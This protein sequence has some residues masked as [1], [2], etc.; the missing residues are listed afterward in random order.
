M[1][2]FDKLPPEDF[3]YDKVDFNFLVELNM[4]LHFIK[5]SHDRLKQNQSNHRICEVFIV[6]KNLING[7]LPSLN[8]KIV[9][10]EESQKD[11][12]EIFKNNRN[13]MVKAIEKDLEKTLK[14]DTGSMKL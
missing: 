5:L 11:L 2:E 10:T 8:Q 3:M 14:K 13:L 12:N 6:L 1:I 7:N 9:S 4:L